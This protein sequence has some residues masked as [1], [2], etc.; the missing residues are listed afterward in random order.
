MNRIVILGATSGIGLEIAKLYIAAG[1]QVGAAGRRTENLEALRA[2]APDRVKIRS[3]DITA[4]EAEELLLRL[5]ADLGGCDLLLHC[6]GIGYN[7]PQL[8]AAREI[9]TAET[10]TVGFTRIMDTAFDYFR[11]QGG[12]HLAA[13]SS[14]AGT[15]GL[16]AAAA[17]SASKRYQ[18]TYLDALAQL[19]RMQRLDIRITD[20]R[21]GFVDTPLLREGK[22]PMLMR[23]E[24]VAAR[25][26]RALGQR[27]GRREV[28]PCLGTWQTPRSDRPPLRPAGAALATDPAGSVGAAADPHEIRPVSKISPDTPCSRH[29]YP[30]LKFPQ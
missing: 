20:I 13:I 7:N 24:K 10:N 17:Y 23:P 15:K 27:E 30:P 8:D 26:V 6:A 14:I 11:K 3:I 21:P 5:I 28:V 29:S 12:G 9:A 1:W 18:N 25:I 16:G 19:S 2:A 4:P 22:Y